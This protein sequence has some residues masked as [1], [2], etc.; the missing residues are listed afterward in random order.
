MVAGV[1]AQLTITICASGTG[2]QFYSSWYCSQKSVGRSLFTAVL[3]PLLLMLWQA[4]VMPNALYRFAWVSPL[5]PPPFL[6]SPS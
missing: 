2:G 4:L 5:H 6:S 1:I 3:P